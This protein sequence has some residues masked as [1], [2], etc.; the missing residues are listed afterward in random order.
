M[1]IEMGESLLQSY[2]K[3]VK[4]CLIS[5][6]NWKT[7]SN[8][9]IEQINQDNLEHIYSKIKSNN[10]FSDVFKKNE[11]DQILRQAEIDVLG[12]SNINTVYMVE[13]AFHEGGLNYG[14][15]IET[16]NKIFEKLLRAYLIGLAYFPEKKLEI[17]FAT[18]KT[19]P[20][21]NEI[22]NDYFEILERE[23]S[24]DKV[25]FKFITNHDF[26]TE[27]LKPTLQLT[28][29]D[30]DTSELFLRSYKLLNMFDFSLNKNED[31]LEN[32]PVTTPHFD[33]SS[34]ISSN[35]NPQKVPVNTA[36][37]NYS[38][39]VPP[40]IEFYVQG[41]SVSK[42]IFNQALLII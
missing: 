30:S 39:S 22:I 23:F 27:I 36:I 37:N 3:H 9:N 7:S 12:L 28:S 42:S 18:P 17:I 2:L 21:T 40:K 38:L 16:K 33:L 13:V 34:L 20:A 35:L 10:E 41:Q 26:N 25:T 11:L 4:N 8:W 32:I 6:T 29:D 19:N 5:Q 31:K 24:S 15:K 14:S 1:K